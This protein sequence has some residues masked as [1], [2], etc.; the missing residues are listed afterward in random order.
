MHSSCPKVSH[1]ILCNKFENGGLKHVDISSKI[2]SLQFSWF[3]KLCDQNFHEWKIISSHLINKYFGK[4]F[5]FHPC[6]SF[7]GKLL[8]KF[9]QF[10]K[11]IVCFFRTTFLHLSH[12]LW[13]KKHILIEKK[14]HLFRYFS[15]KSL[16]FVYQLFDNYGKR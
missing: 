4:S 15:D 10:Y 14:V 12:F 7:D 2:I 16:N 1:K 13:F 9:P 6:F 11:S 5:K 8:I 3:R